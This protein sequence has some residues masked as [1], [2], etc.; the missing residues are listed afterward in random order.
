MSK[1]NFIAANSEGDCLFEVVGNRYLAP[2]YPQL[3]ANS[4][5]AYDLGLATVIS[6]TEEEKSLV[7]EKWVRRVIESYRDADNMFDWCFLQHI[8]FIGPDSANIE[9]M[10]A[11]ECYLCALGCLSFSS[12]PSLF[13]EILPGPYVLIEQ[14]LRE[15]FKVV[16]DANTTCAMTLRSSSEYCGSSPYFRLYRPVCH[17][18]PVALRSPCNRFFAFVIPTPIRTGKGPRSAG[19]W[20][21]IDDDINI[22]GIASSV[23]NR[24]FYNIKSPTPQSVKCIKVLV[25]LGVA[26]VG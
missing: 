15:V 25:D 10:P 7:T 11:A 3:N 17:F 1:A 21:V 5:W 19:L 12:D 16:D 6:L 24:V 14:C 8:I 22:Q 9:M 26:I 2:F 20:V 18:T 13:P 4:P 23:G